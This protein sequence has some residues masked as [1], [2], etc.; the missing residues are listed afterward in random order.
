VWRGFPKRS[1][2]IK[3]LERD[4]DSAKSHR[5]L[6]GRGGAAHMK[7]AGCPKL[8]YCAKLF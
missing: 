6:A 7:S 4:D 1:C 2:S 8:N 3:E 5:A